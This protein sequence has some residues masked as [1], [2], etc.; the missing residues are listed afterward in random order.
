[1]I[2]IKKDLNVFQLGEEQTTQFFYKVPCAMYNVPYSMYNVP[3]AVY[4]VP[5]A[6]CDVPGAMY[7]VPCAMCDVHVV[8]CGFALSPFTKSSS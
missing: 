7:N 2:V 3:C 1:M 4:N 8:Q 6:M 5:C